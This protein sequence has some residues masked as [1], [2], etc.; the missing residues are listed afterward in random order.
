M[1]WPRKSL[2]RRVT[3][4]F[5][6]GNA[7]AM[8]LFLLAMYP[9]ELDEET[10]PVGPELPLLAVAQD[11]VPLEGK[12]IGL[13]RGGLTSEFSGRHPDMWFIARVGPNRLAFGPVPEQAPALLERLPAGLREARFRGFGRPGPTGEGIVSEVETAAGTAL[14]AA[15]GVA[16][17]SL[18]YRDYLRYMFGNEFHWIPLLAAA[19]ALGGAL[20]VAPILLRGIRPTVGAAAD[21]G[22]GDLE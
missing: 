16:T 15:G 4:A 9:A 19:L 22:S 17:G 14:V 21:I 12:G 10:Q 5:V 1:K 2:A 7:A 8:L 13:R 3:L 6:L 18:T 20:L 11:L